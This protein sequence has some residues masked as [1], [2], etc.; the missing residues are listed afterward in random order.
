MALVSF[1][2]QGR[3]ALTRAEHRVVSL[4]IL[5]ESNAQI[6]HAISVSERTVASHLARAMR[7]LRVGSRAELA[8]KLAALLSPREP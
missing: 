2:I 3:F 8:V 5:G 4:A 7:K 6:A 1:P